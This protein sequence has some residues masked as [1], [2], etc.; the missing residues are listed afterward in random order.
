MGEPTFEGGL[1][2]KG[3]DA[4]QDFNEVFRLPTSIYL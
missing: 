4:L 2:V 3:F 1:V